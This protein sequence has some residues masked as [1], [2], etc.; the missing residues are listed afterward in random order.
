MFLVT[1]GELDDM[2]VVTPSGA[3]RIVARDVFLGELVPC[4]DCSA[5]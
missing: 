3:T 5:Y 1:G 4:A 2:L